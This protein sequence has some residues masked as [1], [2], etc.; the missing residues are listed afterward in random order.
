MGCWLGNPLGH[1]A[2]SCWLLE[3]GVRISHCELNGNTGQHWRSNSSSHVLVS[4]FSD[5]CTILIIDMFHIILLSLFSRLG[6]FFFFCS[7]LLGGFPS[8]PCL[9]PPYHSC[10]VGPWSMPLSPLAIDNTYFF[11]GFR[12]RLLELEEG[13]CGREGRTTDCYSVSSRFG[14]FLGIF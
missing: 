2:L 9:F 7:A 12:E 8:S 14:W 1:D 3:A 11:P 5:S 4:I 10:N 13:A 6:L